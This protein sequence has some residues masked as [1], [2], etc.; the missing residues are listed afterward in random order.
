[1]AL[2]PSEESGAM[3]ESLEHIASL[4]RLYDIRAQLRCGTAADEYRNAIIVLYSQILEYQAYMACHLSDNSIVRGLHSILQSSQWMSF[5]KKI[6]SADEYC[7]K[8]EV[9]IEKK[10]ERAEWKQQTNIMENSNK[11]QE[12]I[13]GA[14]RDVLASRAADR[15]D[16][17]Q[18]EILHCL[19]ADYSGH[20]NVNPRRVPDTCR[21]FLDD[22][23]FQR[24]RDLRHSS[25]LWLVTGPGCGKSVLSRALIDD[26]L[27]TTQ[28]MTSTVCYFF[29]KD[30]LERRQRGEDALCGIL[31]QLYSQNLASGLITH[32]Y[33]PFKSN[34]PGI[35]S[36]FHPLW[37]LLITTAGD[38]STGEVLC[39]LDALDECQADARK[40]LMDQLEQFCNDPRLNDPNGPCIKFLITSRPINDVDKFLS[41]FSQA[42]NIVRFDGDEQTNLIGEEINLVIDKRI[43]EIVPQLDRISQSLISENLKASKHRTYLWLHLILGEIDQKF[44]IYDD[45]NSI[46]ELIA[47]LPE[48]VSAAYEKILNQSLD[49][50]ITWTILKIIVAAKRPLTEIELAVAEAVIRKNQARS[51]EDLRLRDEGHA[52]NLRKICGFFISIHDS[53]VYLIHQTARE[54]LLTSG[55]HPKQSTHLPRPNPQV[56]QHSLDIV[57]AEHTM[58]QA[59][60]RLLQFHVFNEKQPWSG[61]RGRWYNWKDK[62]EHHISNYPLLKYASIEWPWHYRVSQYLSKDEEIVLA[63]KICD[64]N[65]EYTK[66]GFPSF[67]IQKRELIDD[68]P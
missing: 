3:I 57:D 66:H 43:P 59:C 9:L 35:R 1:L 20:K 60:I 22:P 54:F 61:Y 62:F 40:Q 46:K 5:V 50:A 34:G 44:P 45:V 27:L 14:V 51:Y 19:A 41:R 67:G 15:E 47:D 55:P 30:G 49:R 39:L 12:Q 24:W 56:W 23:R 29:F 10:D 7:Q 58:A 11:I 18:K 25:L 53:K 6:D 48:S 31:H 33:Q 13:L 64:V 21:W 42:I 38:S 26:M 32:A 63:Q 36:M 16:D 4:I 68:P 17:R 8:H 2:A 52:S 65:S 37:D 28:M